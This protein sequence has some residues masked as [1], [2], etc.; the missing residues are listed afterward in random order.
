MALIDHK[1]REAAELYLTEDYIQHNPH[2]ATGRKAFV[3]FFDGFASQA[4]QANTEIK[5]SFADGDFVI[6]HA[7]LKIDPK[8]KGI[9]VVDIFRVEGDKVVEHWDVLQDIPEDPKN[10]NTMF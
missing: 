8:S 2:A 5:R 1:H 7:H 9:A 6:V 3:E 4:P 10:E